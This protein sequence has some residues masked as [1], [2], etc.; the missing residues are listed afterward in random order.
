MDANEAEFEYVIDYVIAEPDDEVKPAR[1]TLRVR[2][3]DPAPTPGCGPAI[4]YIHRA[5]RE[6][7]RETDPDAYA[8]IEHPDDL[9]IVKLRDA[10]TAEA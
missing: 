10:A 2:V 8:R 5:L 9:V 3:V 4:A 7:I 1:Q 6:A